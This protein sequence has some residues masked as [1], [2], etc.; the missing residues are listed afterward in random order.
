MKLIDTDIAIDHFHG[1]R[2][3]LEYLTQALMEGEILAM[4]V[5]GLMEILA[6]MAGRTGKNRKVIPTF[7]DCGCG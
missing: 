4:S 7:Y 2:A 1:H 6:D 5:I 3:T